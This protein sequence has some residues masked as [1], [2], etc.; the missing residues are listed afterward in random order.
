MAEPKKG[1]FEPGAPKTQVP[2]I[3]KG[4]KWYGDERGPV[5]KEDREKARAAYIAK[6]RTLDEMK[7]TYGPLYLPAQ[8]NS[9]AKM[10]VHMQAVSNHIRENVPIQKVLG[11]TEHHGVIALNTSYV[12]ADDKYV[13]GQGRFWAFDPIKGV[14]K[15]GPAY[16]LSLD[17]PLP[18]TKEGYNLTHAYGHY[19]NAAMYPNK[20]VIKYVYRKPVV[21]KNDNV[22][23]A[24]AALYPDRYSGK[25]AKKTTRLAIS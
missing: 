12:P 2:R 25:I 16:K 3:D 6:K 17:Q 19:E 8:S 13:T 22:T 15:G 1:R 18:E 5:Y 24:R 7:T 11:R 9:L 23:A 10:K 4:F 14:I 21:A 20:R